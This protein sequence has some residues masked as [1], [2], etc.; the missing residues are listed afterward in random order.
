MNNRQKFEKGVKDILKQIM[1]SNEMPELDDFGME[2]LAY[3]CQEKLIVGVFVDRMAAG[4]LVAEYSNPKITDAGLNYLYP[5]K[6]T[7]F[8]VSTSIAVIE[9]VVIIIQA[10]VGALAA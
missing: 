10:I 6:D 3:C 1:I 7:K 5:K 4:N 9:L 2:C 8:I